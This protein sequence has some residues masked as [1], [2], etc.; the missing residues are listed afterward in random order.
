M[1]QPPATM[2]SFI[3]IIMKFLFVRGIRPSARWSQC[4]ILLRRLISPLR[5]RFAA[6]AN[7]ARHCRRDSSGFTAKDID[8]PPRRPPDHKPYGTR[9]TVPQA[10]SALGAF[11]LPHSSPVDLN[12]SIARGSQPAARLPLLRR[13]IIAGSPS[14]SRPQVNHCERRS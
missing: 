13:A 12:Q 3:H 7:P 9:R 11:V 14:L 5:T 2:A 10:A 8:A 6:R 4:V 1:S